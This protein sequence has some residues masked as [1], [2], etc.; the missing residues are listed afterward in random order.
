MR[1]VPTFWVIVVL[2]AV[3]LTLGLAAVSNRDAFQ[4]IPR[5][6][7]FQQSSEKG[8]GDGGAAADRARDG[9]DQRDSALS[10]GGSSDGAVDSFSD[11]FDGFIS[12]GA[13]GDDTFMARSL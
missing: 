6:P 4:A 12:G 2:S 10:A 3:F 11:S 9:D 5:I 13:S 8:D 1:R 7:I